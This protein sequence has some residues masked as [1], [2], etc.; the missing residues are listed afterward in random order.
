ML[1]N[2]EIKSQKIKDDFRK[3]K[4]MSPGALEK[5]LTLSWSVWMFGIESFENSVKRLKNSGIDWIEL[6]GDQHTAYSGLKLREV[7]KVLAAYDLKVS[8]A[9]GMF[10]KENDLSSNSPFVVQKAIDYIKRQVEFLAEVGG[11]YLIVVPSA[12][13]RPTAIDSWEFIRSASALKSC[14]DVFEQTGV[15]IAIEPIRSAEVSI[16]HSIEQAQR[17]IETVGDK[18]VQHINADTY[19][20][21]LEETH[22]G[23]SILSA[24]NQLI[25]IHIA[26]SNRDA[27]GTGMIDFDTVIRALYLIGFNKRGGYVTPE[28]LG[29]FPDPY[30]LSNSPCNQEIMDKLVK[31]TVSYFLSREEEVLQNN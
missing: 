13:G 14:S 3:L 20:M 5:K 19:H 12:V 4:E 15:K 10:S 28:P 6:K 29:P 17:Y 1:Q 25:N 8:G 16:V 30:V 31:D 22:I 11:E 26:D 7:K 21:L 9:C 27:P 18:G 23:E 24:G 2:Y